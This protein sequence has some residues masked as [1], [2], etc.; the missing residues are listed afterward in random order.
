MSSTGPRPPGDHPIV[1]DVATVVRRLPPVAELDPCGYA[2]A[3]IAQHGRALVAAAAATRPDALVLADDDVAVFAAV[4][5]H[6]RVMIVDD[7][8]AHPLGAW[9][10]GADMA[11]VQLA[12][13]LRQ[14]GL[15]V[16]YA[17]VL[18][19]GPGLIAWRQRLA[20]GEL[21]LDATDVDVTTLPSP[22]VP[23]HRLAAATIRAS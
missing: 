2:A 6:P 18:M 11:T 14:R 12:A 3:V 23:P 7:A 20:A 9:K 13:A 15:A 10:N 22:N 8:A 19:E 21:G 5:P 4:A 16:R 1:E 17:A